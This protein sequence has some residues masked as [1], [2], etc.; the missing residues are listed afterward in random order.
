MIFTQINKFLYNTYIN[1]K[2]NKLSRDI[3]I[4]YPSQASCIDVV[5]NKPVGECLRALYYDIT[6]TPITNPPSPS[7]IRKLNYGNIGEEAEINIL[8]EMGILV[9]KQKS[10]ELKIDPIIIKGRVD[11]IINLSGLKILEY[12]TSGG[13]TFKSEVF[14]TVKKNGF[15]KIKNL[16]QAMIYIDYFSKLIE[17][18]ITECDLMY[19]DRESLATKEFKVQ[20]S[21]EGNP[22][23]ND[24]LYGNISTY[25][26][27]NRLSSLYNTLKDNKIPDCDY[28]CCYSLDIATEEFR[29]G[30]IKKYQFEEAKRNGYCK[31]SNCSYCPYLTKCQIDN[32]F[33]DKYEF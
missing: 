22:I 17:N 30:E 13:Y 24:E 16:M 12:K 10:F 3:N 18:P 23:I 25:G 27:Y 5:T 7:N 21:P 8:E 33:I 9:E 19:I 11:A 26:I 15:P 6:N 28:R 32:N 1:K 29:N 2:T 31:D 20:L 4:F 14:G